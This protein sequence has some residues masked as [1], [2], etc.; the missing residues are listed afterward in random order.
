MRLISDSSVSRVYAGFL[1][2]KK[3]CGGRCQGAAQ[4]AEH[5]FT[6]TEV[7]ISMLIFAVGV[8]AV[9]NMQIMSSMT[10]SGSR[11]M[12][13]AVIVAQ[14]TLDQL[15]ALGKSDARLK[16]RNNNGAG[17]LSADT[18]TSSDGNDQ[19]YAEFKLDSKYR[20][21]WN[22][23]DDYPFTGNKTIRAIVRWSERGIARRY[24]LETKMD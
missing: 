15:T 13:E 23:Q 4:P 18:D 17:G 1:A 3:A 5:G 12:T 22:I 9:V 2:R 24:T 8:L 10:N 16:D 21:Y 7:L 6:L 20:V 11:G 19:L 14:S